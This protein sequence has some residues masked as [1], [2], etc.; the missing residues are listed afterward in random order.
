MDLFIVKD[1]II[2]N[3]G[4]AHGGDLLVRNGRIE[5]VGGVIDKKGA[6]EVI[7]EG[8]YV[9]PG[10]ID[11]QVHFRDPGLNQKASIV[12]ES[13]AAAMG[14]VT[15]F[16]DMPNTKP[17]TLTVD[18]LEEKYQLAKKTSTINYSFYMGTSNDNLDE[19]LKVDTEKVCGVK[20]FMGASTGNLLVDDEQAL[21]GFFSQSPA[22][23]ATHCEDE[24]T[25]QKNK[26]LFAEKYGEDQAPY[27]HPLIRSTHSCILS[28]R[29]AVVLAKKYNTR[30]HV[31]HLSTADEMG[32][33]EN[34]LPLS[35][36]RI[37]AEACVHHLY[38]S[39]E[40]YKQ[41]G[42][43]LVCN[44]A[45]K[46]AADRE[47][48]WKAL[49]DDRLD[50]IATDHAPHTLEEKELPY[51]IAPSGLPLVQH[52][53]NMMLSH[54]QAGRISI[55]KIVEKMCHA[56]AICFKIKERGYLSEG[57]YA[58]FSLVDMN[59]SW[60]V[61]PDNIA[62][63]C[64]WSPLEGVEFMGKVTDTFVNGLGVFRD[65]RITGTKSAERLLFNN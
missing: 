45:V 51:G 46:T 62:Y 12:T 42:N 19:V 10:I 31:L 53:L 3:E 55:E 5:K 30:L 6:K 60:K 8:K 32:L 39:D 14:G 23:I 58:D 61:E 37:T 36:K 59:K 50:I 18:L 41:L 52:S 47:G 64:G 20:I 57:Y 33:F 63:K 7:A 4:V 21:E 15:S 22:L 35:E 29:K 25:I 40:D 2:V 38:F 54:M 48:I 49:M 24:A 44:P 9:L 1:G 28:S 56:P 65:C 11:D 16:M 26:L 17:A 43:R 27:M 13:I 34:K